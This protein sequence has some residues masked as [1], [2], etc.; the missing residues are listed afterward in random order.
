M[1]HYKPLFLTLLLLI[2]NHAPLDAKG[3]SAVITE[4]SYR[5]R[6]ALSR[7]AGD[8]KN[9]RFE[10]ARDELDSVLQSYGQSREFIVYR[11][12]HGELENQLKASVKEA[13]ATYRMVFEKIVLSY[14]ASGRDSRYGKAL[15]PFSGA[16]YIDPK[17]PL[18]DAL[19]QWLEDHSDELLRSVS[20][21]SRQRLFVESVVFMNRDENWYQDSRRDR[22]LL[23]TPAG[24]LNLRST[25]SKMYVVLR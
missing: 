5:I 8:I 11:K 7:A 16:I 4:A 19:N 18:E 10:D 20:V 25:Y 24:E 6:D 12:K 22:R 14:R 9:Q 13:N 1:I 21:N 17:I 2:L 3:G 15:L 23:S